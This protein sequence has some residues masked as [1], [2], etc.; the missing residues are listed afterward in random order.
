M[1]IAEL[2]RGPQEGI[3]QVIS[4]EDLVTAYKGR[5]LVLSG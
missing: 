5:L 3:L 1:I 4:E 2:E